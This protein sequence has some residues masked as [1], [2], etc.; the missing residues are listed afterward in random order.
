[1]RAVLPACGSEW[2]ETPH[3]QRKE[4][5][6][7]PATVYTERQ[8]L[9]SAFTPLI[10]VRLIWQCA[11]AL[12]VDLVAEGFTLASGGEDM[13]HAFRGI[14]CAPGDLCANIVGVRD[15]STLA[16]KYMQGFAMF[17]GY[18]AAVIQFGR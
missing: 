6:Y 15:P 17:F 3:R 13:P 10:V 8:K 11:V 16:W 2:E 14:P 1:M 5:K 4:G 7:N 18:S 9:C 12:G